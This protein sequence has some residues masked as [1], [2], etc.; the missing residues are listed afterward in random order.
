MLRVVGI[1]VLGRIF[2]FQREKVTE[3]WG[4]LGNELHE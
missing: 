2:K 4:K 3:G 1:S